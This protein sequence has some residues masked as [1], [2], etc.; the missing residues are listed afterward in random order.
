MGGYRIVLADD[1]VLVRQGLRRLVEDV[2]D[3]VVVGEAGDG[4]ELLSLLHTLIPDMVILDISMPNLRGIDVVS[5]IK[6]RC[7]ETKVLILSMHKEY[8]H[9][10]VS[11]GVDGYLLKEEADRELFSAIDN[12]RQ[13][14]THISSRL[15]KELIGGRKLFDPLSNREKEVLKLIAAG[16]SNREIA[17]IL[18]ISVRTAEKHRATI[19]GK[20]KAKNTADLVKHAIQKGYV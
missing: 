15:S 11:A 16:K 9:Q 4:I 1:H 12:I 8:L 10:A 19:I 7:P 2:G 20:L 5:E 17:D 6:K 14:R 3:L 13:E 18:F